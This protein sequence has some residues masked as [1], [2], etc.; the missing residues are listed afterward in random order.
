MD[1]VVGYCLYLETMGME[2]LLMDPVECWLTHIIL[3]MGE[4]CILMQKRDGLVNQT[5]SAH[6]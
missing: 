5:L 3:S 4:M 2:T 1:N 6:I